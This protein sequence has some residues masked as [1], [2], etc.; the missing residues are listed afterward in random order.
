[1]CTAVINHL[2][3]T[4]QCQVDMAH[5][6]A[7]EVTVWTTSMA[8]IRLDHQ[9]LTAAIQANFLVRWAW[10]LVFQD[11]SS[12]LVEMLDLAWV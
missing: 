8:L 9:G 1:M 6:Q 3:V 10:S 11:R 7:L 4:K 12:T 2:T 5:H